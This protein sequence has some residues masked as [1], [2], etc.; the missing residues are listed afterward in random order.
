MRT[1]LWLPAALAILV[2]IV[3]AGIIFL[4]SQPLHHS[5]EPNGA[6]KNS[7]LSSQNQ[8]ADDELEANRLKSE[9][10]NS[11][12][13]KQ[14]STSDEND[15]TNAV[16]GT[17]SKNGIGIV[18]ATNSILDGANHPQGTPPADQT[19]DARNPQEVENIIAGVVQNIKGWPIRGAQIQVDGGNSVQSEEGGRFS[20]P[21]LSQTTVSLQVSYAGYQTLR[22]TDVEVGNKNL[23]LTLVK[24]GTL[25]GRVVDQFQ[26]GIA[27]ANVSMKAIQG[28]WMIDL[29][30]DSQGR[31]EAGNAPDSRVKVS[32]TQEGFKD[33]GSG[34]REVD[35]PSMEEIVL[36]LQQP[37]FSISGAVIMRETRQG[38]GGFKLV[39][40]YQ[41]EG[42]DTEELITQTDGTGSYR[43]ENLKRGT[44]LVSSLS[45]ENA[46]LNVVIPLEEDFKSVRVFEWDARNIN[47]EAV[48]G[49]QINGTVINSARQPVGGAEVTIAR[50]E[51]VKTTS[52]FDGRFQLSGVPVSFM[53]PSGTS[54]IMRG[55]SG[56]QLY[57]SHPDHGS[58]LSDPL[59]ADLQTGLTDVVIT[60]Q[61]N[62][63]L[64]G[65]VRDRSGMAVSGAQIVLRDLL[66]G[67][68]DEQITDAG[69]AFYFDKVTATP[70]SENRFG[71]THSIEVV[72]EGYGALHREVV[73]RSGEAQT[74]DLVLEGGGSISGR[75]TDQSGSAIADV[76][77]TAYLP[78]GGVVTGRS[79]MVGTYALTSLP[80]GV[81]DLAFRLNTNPPLT[82]Y[83]YQIPAGSINVDVVLSAGEWMVNG[84]VW[85]DVKKVALY[86]YAMAIE[87]NPL[88]PGG[89][90][91][92]QQKWINSADGTY[93]LSFTEPGEYRIRFT[94]D[95]YYP[96]D[97]KVM[98]APH[99]AREQ[100]LNGPMIPRDT[101]GNISGVFIPP[102]GMMLARIDVLGYLPFPM[103]GNEFLLS[104][105]PAGPY[106]LLFYVR[107][108]ATMGI[109]QGVLPSV[110]VRENETT[111]LG[112]VT[113]QRLPY[114]L[115]DQ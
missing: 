63:S 45:S 50:L 66:Q 94:A 4:P 46:G 114:V 57:A 103:N 58:G 48:S 3:I 41:K 61:G 44:Y 70:L 88:G 106:D 23:V 56:I 10:R 36:Q 80:E 1:H 69:G 90:K 86:Q 92:Y 98:I 28:I 22:K 64:S 18:S 32:A 68:R 55:F 2:V 16:N 87:G 25:T 67:N 29:T 79:D 19:G 7:T 101:K 15:L 81:F 78:T 20:I 26:E 112:Q 110:L 24:E 115:R 34:S 105:I 42:E 107:D 52:S 54:S 51:S 93:Q 76:M 99:T 96:S 71:G 91:F 37:S 49:R 62:S 6:T 40:K 5:H 31:F 11:N 21:D 108:S 33:A 83:L 85:D 97:Q 72:K 77:V 73:I 47:F 102:E 17:D 60:L 111:N 12:E 30:A 89:S 100:I 27:F 75:V 53:D 74:I 8:P 109:K 113:V 59:P 39:A 43:F 9:T 82:S 84:T 38:V 65:T 35:S 13:D 95:G 104:D 14:I